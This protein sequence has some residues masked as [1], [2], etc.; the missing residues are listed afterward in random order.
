MKKRICIIITF[1]LVL[2][3]IILTATGALSHKENTD[4][5][6]NAQISVERVDSSLYMKEDIPAINRLKKDTLKKLK[7]VKNKED[8]DKIH[9]ITDSFGDS[10]Y[11]Y[12]TVHEHI[13]LFNKGLKSSISDLSPEQQIKANEI[14]KTYSEK[15][16][17]AKSRKALDKLAADIATEIS[18][19]TGVPVKIINIYSIISDASGSVLRAPEEKKVKEDKPTS[20]ENQENEEEVDKTEDED[21]N[22]ENIYYE[23]TNSSNSTNR[24]PSHNNSPGESGSNNVSPQPTPTPEPTPEPTPTPTP[25]PDN[26]DENNPAVEE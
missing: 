16:K 8:V 5:L 25:E 2:V 17:K 24:T 23:D 13:H 11:K 10:L 7:S 1:A 22:H 9:E 14:I 20:T 26:K 21:H 15:I 12:L 6:H 19:T 3:M 18:I 4:I